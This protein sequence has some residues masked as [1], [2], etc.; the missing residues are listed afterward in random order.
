MTGAASPTLALTGFA[1]PNSDSPLDWALAYAAAGLAVFPVGAE[2]RPLTE[3]GVKDA[4]TDEAQIRGWWRDGLTRTPHGR[5]RLR[6]RRRPRLQGARTVSGTSP[7]TRGR[8]PTTWPRRRL[9][10]RGGAV[11]RLRG[12]RRD[13]QKH[14]P[15]QRLVDR[16]PDDRRLHRLPAPG[17][18]RTW[19]TPLTTPLAPVPN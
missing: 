9:R 18:G 15:P 7:S 10:R 2:K 11:S 5:S 14:H 17:N 19:V 1:P 12:K 13:V 6:Y 16:S 3:H 8:T 4:T